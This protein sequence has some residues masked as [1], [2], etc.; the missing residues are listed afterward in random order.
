M[1]FQIQ[2]A[3]SAPPTLPT[4]MPTPASTKVFLLPELLVS[5]IACLPKVDILTRA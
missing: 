5:I 4:V 3:V 2:R 1:S